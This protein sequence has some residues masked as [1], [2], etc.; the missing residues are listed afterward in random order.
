MS[1]AD[2]LGVGSSFNS[3]RPI[4]ARR[5]A[6]AAAT[7]APTEGAPEPTE[8]PTEVISHNPSNPRETL[9]RIDELA[10][11]IS[12]V[13]LVAAITVARVSSYLEERSDQAHRL[14]PQAQYVVVDGHRR[15]EACRRAGVTPIK[16]RVDDSYVASDQTLLETAFVANY[17]SDNMTDLEQANALDTLVTFYGGQ[18]KAAKRLGISQATIASKLS[19]LRLTPELQADLAEG[20]RKAEHV[21]NLGKLSPEE[22]RATADA[23]AA[24]AAQRAQKRSKKPQVPEEEPQAY[25]AV[26]SADGSSA[27][28]PA[29]APSPVPTPSAAAPSSAAEEEE[30]P[31]SSTG[32]AYE[33]ETTTSGLSTKVQPQR[34]VIKVEE[35]S[36]QAL[37]SA[38]RE[39][40]S[41]G[42]INELIS[43]LHG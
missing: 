4:S 26:I 41:E 20:R 2:R 16:V 12:E 43:E 37:A 27:E 36:P 29:P 38:L 8:L 39:H 9:P 32:S 25:H 34:L 10:D 19:L 21:R 6:T 18:T 33:Q 13:G 35:R 15:L 42:E 7:E 17:H 23:R 30:K 5:A 11:T 28:P 31:R 24:E 22:Q 14:D 40:L 1:K 3:A